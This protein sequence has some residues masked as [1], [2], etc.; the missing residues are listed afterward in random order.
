M[1]ASGSEKPNS[2]SAAQD[3]LWRRLKP[4]LAELY[5]KNMAHIERADAAKYLTSKRQRAAPKVDY[6][7][8]L[9]K[10]LHAKRPLLV[11]SSQSMLHP[12]LT[13]ALV[14]ALPV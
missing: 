4:N 11:L 2:K 6:N 5:L 7:A 8:V 3:S 13:D 1:S 9:H 12:S 10:L 14:A